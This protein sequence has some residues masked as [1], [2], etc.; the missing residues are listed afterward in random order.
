[1]AK[2]KHIYT[3]KR[4]FPALCYSGCV[5]KIRHVFLCVVGGGN[6]LQI[7][8]HCSGR[9]ILSPQPIFYLNKLVPCF[10]VNLTLT[11]NIIER[12]L[13]FGKP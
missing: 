10:A 7:A 8:G 6:I 4:N 1:M 3:A 2:V 11:K 5:T 12:V 9:V 13:N